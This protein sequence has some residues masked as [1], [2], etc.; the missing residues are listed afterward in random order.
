MNVRRV[1]DAGEVGG[2]KAALGVRGAQGGSNGGKRLTSL[3]ASAIV[4]SLAGATPAGCRNGNDAPTAIGEAESGAA[5][6]ETA[7]A[8]VASV[9]VAVTAAVVGGVSARH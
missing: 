6:A 2:R 5:G 7:G 1:A 8:S 9:A 4:L 3:A